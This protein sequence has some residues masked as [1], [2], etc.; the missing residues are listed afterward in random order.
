[1]DEMRKYF[2]KGTKNFNISSSN[3]NDNV[4][5]DNIYIYY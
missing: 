5:D 1:M 4:N 3:N 2:P